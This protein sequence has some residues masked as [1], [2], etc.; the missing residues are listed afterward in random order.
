MEASK[1]YG[2]DCYLTNKVCCNRILDDLIMCYRSYFLCRYWLCYVD[3]EAVFL[4]G[5]EFWAFPE[6]FD[7]FLFLKLEGERERCFHFLSS[8]TI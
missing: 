8:S 3:H 4:A 2:G 6:G 1:W 7:L 5:L